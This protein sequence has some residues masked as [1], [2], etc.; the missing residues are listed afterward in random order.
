M[1]FAKYTFPLAFLAAGWMLGGCSGEK[2]KHH[3]VEET[4]YPAYAMASAL[5]GKTTVDVSGSTHAF[6]F[7]APN[8]GEALLEQHLE[9]DADFELAFTSGPNT[10]FPESD[11]LGPVFNHTSCNGCHQKDGRGNL[12]IVPSGKNL[13]KLGVNESVF[14]RISLENAVT[15]DGGANGILKDADNMWGAPVPVPQFGTQLFHRG[16]PGVR[17][18]ASIGSGQADV[19]MKY[20]THTVTYGDGSE[21]KLRKPLF[22]VDNPYDDADDPD[23]YDEKNASSSELFAADVK[24]GP[25]IGMPMIGLGLLEAVL[26]EDILALADVDDTDGDGISGKPNMVFDAVKYEACQ[27]A[28]NCDI[29]PPLSLGRFGWKANTPSVRQQSL[30][31][32]RGDIGITNPLAGE[33]SIDGTNMMVDYM[34][35]H[36][37]YA[38]YKATDEGAVEGDAALADSLVVYSQTLAVPQRRNVDDS[39]VKKGAALFES[40]KCT[41]CHTPSFT[42]GEHEITALSGQIIYPFSDMLLHD[43]GEGLA[44]GRRDF[45]AG[46]SEWKT[47]PLWG[48]G[49]TQVINPKAGFLHDGRARTIE[50]AV[51]WHGGEAEAAKERFRVLEKSGRDSLVAFIKSL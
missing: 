20:E 17:S 27:L 29:N 43:M 41:A 51:L 26:E 11:G 14:L 3:T 40:L 7:P 28:G 47:R 19:W 18:D 12:P 5:G 42:T 33:E 21:A 9:G 49:M 4:V 24:M 10:D 6:S 45:D 2:E 50:E 1:I 22:M 35:S 30:G 36:P 25:R 13:V 48:I 32:L 31:A 44:D 34:A 46:G 37:E 38:A 39:Q 23:T 16:V 8:L 15:Y